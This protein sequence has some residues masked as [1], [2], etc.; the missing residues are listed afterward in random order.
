[1]LFQ[2]HP[3]HLQQ[4]DVSGTGVFSPASISTSVPA[5]LPNHSS[6]IS[7]SSMALDDTAHWCWREILTASVLVK[8][9]CPFVQVQLLLARGFPHS[10]AWQAPTAGH[11]H[12]GWSFTMSQ[13]LAY[14]C[15]QTI[16]TATQTRVT[17]PHCPQGQ[18][19][20]F[21]FSPVRFLISHSSW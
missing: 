19:I 17:V 15:A 14:G 20:C 11:R 9:L 10:P 16:P 13:S 6:E 18:K 7:C 2:V 21:I 8:Q 4:T 1:M 5:P 3:Q 12:H